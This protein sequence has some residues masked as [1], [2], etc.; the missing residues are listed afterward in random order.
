M[1]SYTPTP[2]LFGFGDRL[3][4]PAQLGL[5]VLSASQVLGLWACT[6]VPGSWVCL[7]F[8]F[9]L[10]FVL[11]FLNSDLFLVITYPEKM[12][13]WAQTYSSGGQSFKIKFQCLVCCFYSAFCFK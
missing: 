11:F 12:S 6:R 1:R 9:V 5:T 10:G 2:L 7:G 4:S 13:I 3:G 8:L